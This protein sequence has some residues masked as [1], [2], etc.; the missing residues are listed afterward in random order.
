MLTSPLPNGPRNVFRHP[1]CR[2]QDAQVKPARGPDIRY[3]IQCSPIDTIGTMPRPPARSLAKACPRAC[4]PVDSSH[5]ASTSWGDHTA[6]SCLAGLSSLG[7]R[8]GVLSLTETVK[9]ISLT[10]S[11]DMLL[12]PRL[13]PRSIITGLRR[14]RHSIKAPPEEVPSSPHVDVCP[15]LCPGRDRC[16]GPA[17]V[18]NLRISRRNGSIGPGG[19][20]SRSGLCPTRLVRSSTPCQATALP[21]QGG[22]RIPGVDP[23]EA[24]PRA[25]WRRVG[26]EGLIATGGERDV[27]MNPG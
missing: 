21:A 5:R 23:A 4:S 18:E 9:G 16:R 1:V 19:P 12:R 14:G 2:F 27:S 26:I 13:L 17:G 8:L 25:Q 7:K 20:F 6:T 3:V 10:H 24:Q 15:R 11:R 22:L